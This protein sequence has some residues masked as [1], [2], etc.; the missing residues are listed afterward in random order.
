M[1]QLSSNNSSVFA[2]GTRPRAVSSSQPFEGLGNQRM[3]ATVTSIESSCWWSMAGKKS[4]PRE[5]GDAGSI[6]DAEELR[7]IFQSSLPFPP[8]LELNFHSTLRYLLGHPGSMVRPRLVYQI[9][10]AYGIAHK[11]ALELA[12]AL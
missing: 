7:A 10:A 12:I 4:M 3:V 1:K 6:P 2:F 11:T 8:S 9:A 5:C